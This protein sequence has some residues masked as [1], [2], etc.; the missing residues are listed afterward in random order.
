MIEVQQLTKKFGPVCALRDVSFDVD[1]GQILGFLGPNGAGKSTTMRIL[2]GYLAGD[3]GRVRVGGYDVQ[4]SSREVR[5]LTG[6]LPEGVPVYPEMRVTEYLKFRA[7]IKGVPRRKRRSYID[8]A[9]ELVDI[10]NVKRRVIGTLSR[11]YRQRVGLADALL[12]KPAVLVL[13]EPT[14]GLDPEQV[15]QFRT[16]LRTVGERRTVILSTHILSEVELVCSSVAVIEAGVIVARGTA[17][18][19]RQR[20][21]SSQKIIA[22]IAGPRREVQAALEG[23][24]GVERVNVAQAS[25]GEGDDAS[26]P[27]ASRPDT[28]RPDTSRPDTAAGGS[29]DAAGESELGKP[30]TGGPDAGDTD[31]G[32]RA[33]KRGGYRRYEIYSLGAED[34]REAVFRRVTSA[35][36]GLRHLSQEEVPLEDIFVAL[37]KKFKATEGA[38]A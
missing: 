37:V 20:V 26:M 11:G 35:K 22:E 33:A 36:W 24:P 5:S 14:V 23:E 19:L 18:E 8:E 12:A 34:L 17:R 2:T 6:Y 16:L 4:R 27:D 31:G 25:G 10:A 7:R 32:A 28:S 29:E 21:G 13:D 38:G 9:L 15:R 30:D 3:S 1:E